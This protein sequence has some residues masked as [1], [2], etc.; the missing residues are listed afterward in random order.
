[1]A[2][3]NRISPVQTG[4]HVVNRWIVNDIEL[5]LIRKSNI[6]NLKMIDT[7]TGNAI[8]HPCQFP[9]TKTIE[10]VIGRL[11]QLDVL[12]EWNKNPEFLMPSHKWIVR[13]KVVSLLHRKT[14]NDLIWQ[15]FDRTTGKS[16]QHS[17][18]KCIIPS[19]R[20]H[21]ETRKLIEKI[22]TKS[23]ADIISFLKDFN[24]FIVDH[25]YSKQTPDP[26]YVRNIS[27][28]E[29]LQKKTDMNA[30]K[31]VVGSYAI[32]GICVVAAPFM[33]PVGI[34]VLV[35]GSANMMNNIYEMNRNFGNIQST[36]NLFLK[37]H[38]DRINAF[39]SSTAPFLIEI[40]PISF[41][42]KLDDRVL[43]SKFIWAVTL[44]TYKGSVGNHAKICFEGRKNGKYRCKI[45]HFTGEIVDLYKYKNDKVKL[46]TRSEIWM[47]SYEEVLPVIKLI[48]KER[49]EDKKI[50]YAKFGKR[51]ILKI[52]EEYRGG[53]SNCL[54]W[55]RDKLL[56]LNIELEKNPT[57][58]KI[59]D[60]AEYLFGATRF[61]TRSPSYYVDKPINISI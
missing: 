34:G 22:G 55:A 2:N 29:D 17:A 7:T 1:M 26:E 28:F 35:L 18:I 21:E 57:K 42:S 52:N 51:S 27:I 5:D 45:G 8:S 12:L 6:L 15:I 11:S 13:E 3:L 30:I 47:R 10:D 44:I 48:A 60:E 61:Y 39:R 33:F 40:E 46:S 19:Q 43:V 32:A 20:C 16:I 37:K 41:P 4:E 58:K 36:E 14:T 56:L 24:V 49:D 50:R 9:I 59:K 53:D 23:I 54:D 31:T 38:A 25:S